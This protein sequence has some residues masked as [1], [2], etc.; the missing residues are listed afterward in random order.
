MTWQ[1]NKSDSLINQQYYLI[2]G[3]KTICGWKDSKGWHH[4]LW[5]RK[6]GVAEVIAR[7]SLDELKQIAKDN[8]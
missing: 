2:C 8:K 1:K 7:G 3:N 5:Q 6:Q 4:E